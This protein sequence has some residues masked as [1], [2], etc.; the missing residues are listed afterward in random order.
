MP[1]EL[2]P[3]PVC[4]STLVSDEQHQMKRPGVGWSTYEIAVCPNGHAWRRWMEDALTVDAW[5]EEPDWLLWKKYHY[6]SLSRLRSELLSGLAETGAR[7]VHN[8]DKFEDVVDWIVHELPS[9][10]PDHPETA[11]T[12]EMAEHW[13]RFRR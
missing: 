10:A 12:V 8:R 1:G 13:R 9:V 3:C 6:R 5:Q 11:K 7:P 4:E 2:G